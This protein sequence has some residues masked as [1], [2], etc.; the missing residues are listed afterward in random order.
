M[1]ACFTSTSTANRLPA[2]SCLR[3]PDRWNYRAPKCQPDLRVTR[4][5]AAAVS[6]KSG[7]MYPKKEGSIGFN[8]QFTPTRKPY[9]GSTVK[10]GLF[11]VKTGSQKQMY[12]L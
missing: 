12:Q 10:R 7:R 11:V 1:I 6:T 5:D 9:F 3:G 2:R 4:Y 8:L